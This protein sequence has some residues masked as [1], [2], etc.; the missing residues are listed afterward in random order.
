MKYHSKPTKREPIRKD[1]G[2]PQGGWSINT[3]RDD[4]V[5]GG[6]KMGGDFAER[7][8]NIVYNSGADKVA[9]LFTEIYAAIETRPG[10]S[11][12]A[13]EAIRLQ[14]KEVGRQAARGDQVEAPALT[15]HLQT[16]GQTAP[17]IL[18]FVL[19]TLASPAAGFST[20]VCKT[21]EKVNESFRAT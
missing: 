19:A 2:P 12:E 4:Y 18:E 8:P 11:A 20:L 5:E 21:A 10:T 15:R 9:G 3:G 13:K 6:A 16:L 14:V 7:D 17:D 1:T